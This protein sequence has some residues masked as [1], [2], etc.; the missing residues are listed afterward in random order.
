MCSQIVDEAASSTPFL[1][2]QPERG[3]ELDTTVEKESSNG[4]MVEPASPEERL[5]HRSHVTT[6]VGTQYVKAIPHTVVVTQCR[7]SIEATRQNPLARKKLQHPPGA[8]A[9]CV[10]RYGRVRNGP[11]VQE[12]LGA[13]HAREHLLP[14][15]IAAIAKRTGGKPEQRFSGIA[16]PR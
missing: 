6:G 13:F 1:H 14:V 15:R 2:S 8:G 4:P 7:Q 9:N 16:A 3:V 5:R 10:L 12:K 11:S